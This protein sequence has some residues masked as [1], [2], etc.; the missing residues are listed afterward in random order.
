MYQCMTI[1]LRNK[2][3]VRHDIE[4]QLKQDGSEKM[5]EHE[6]AGWLIVLYV[7][8]TCSSGIENL[9]KLIAF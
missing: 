9:P 2:E 6:C 8:S 4:C 3:V 1:K 5:E 7:A